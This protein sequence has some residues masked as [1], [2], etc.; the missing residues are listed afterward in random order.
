[1]RLLLELLQTALLAAVPAVGFGMAF[2]VPA[3]ILGWC[4]VGGALGRTLRLLLVEAGMPIAWATFLAAA[5]VSWLGV[6]A[7]QRLRA[8]P[9]VFTV[10]AV[11]PMVP[12]VPLYKTLLALSQ[13]QRNGVTNDLLSTALSEGLT[14]TFV[15]AA[16]AVGLAVPGL[17][18]FRR[19]PVI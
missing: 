19:R 7:A 6:W 1:M 9:K 10:A 16:L 3:R 17:F 5:A 8:H 2:H 12:G 14:A 4:A 18:V 13:M 11:I 15:V